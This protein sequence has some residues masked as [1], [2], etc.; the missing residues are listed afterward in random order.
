MAIET[1]LTL[2]NST[3]I[4]ATRTGT[5]GSTTTAYSLLELL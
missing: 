1:H 3:T 4:T 5:A 2:T